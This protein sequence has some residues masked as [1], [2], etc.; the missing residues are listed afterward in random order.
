MEGTVEKGNTVKKGGTSV[1][2]RDSI[3][4]ES[5]NRMRIGYRVSGVVFRVKNAFAF[6]V[7]T[8]PTLISLSILGLCSAGVLIAEF[9]PC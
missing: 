3:W 9:L 2:E 4:V 8:T 6:Y 5:R 1:G 7:E